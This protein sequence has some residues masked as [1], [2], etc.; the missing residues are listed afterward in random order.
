M[1]MMETIVAGVILFVA[2]KLTGEVLERLPNE[3]RFWWLYFIV[4]LLLPILLTL[5]MVEV[6]Q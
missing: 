1:N 3:E 6:I 2:L 4:G 5:L